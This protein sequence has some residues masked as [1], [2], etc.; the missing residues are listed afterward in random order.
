MIADWLMRSPWRWL[1]VGFVPMG[2]TLASTVTAWGLWGLLPFLGMVAAYLL[3]LEVAR[4]AFMAAAASWGEVA[5][6]ERILSGK[7]SKR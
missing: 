5:R 7:G 2:V 1:S 4:E 6:L 3:V